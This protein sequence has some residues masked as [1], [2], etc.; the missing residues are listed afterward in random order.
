LRVPTIEA[1]RDVV[2]DHLHGATHVRLTQT[3]FVLDEQR[4]QIPLP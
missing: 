2:L 3:V 1:L 4:R